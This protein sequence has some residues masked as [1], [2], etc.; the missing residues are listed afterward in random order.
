MPVIVSSSGEY[1]AICHLFS[2]FDDESNKKGGTQSKGFL[3]DTIGCRANILKLAV[4]NF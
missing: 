3:T 1:R 2:F 4:V